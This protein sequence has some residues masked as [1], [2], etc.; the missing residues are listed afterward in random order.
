MTI[1]KLFSEIWKLNGPA[2]II[3]R[4]LEA[5]KRHLKYVCGAIGIK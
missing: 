4:K 1:C 5:V 3:L 2:Q